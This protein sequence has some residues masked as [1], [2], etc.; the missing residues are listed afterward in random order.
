M[1]PWILPDHGPC[2]A[3]SHEIGDNSRAGRTPDTS[4]RLDPNLLLDIPPPVLSNL[5]GYR[6]DLRPKRLRVLDLDPLAVFDVNLAASTPAGSSVI[7]AA[8]T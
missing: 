6:E 2:F 7:S 5:L 3:T 1:I 4:P 8:S